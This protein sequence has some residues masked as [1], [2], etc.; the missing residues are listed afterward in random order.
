MTSTNTKMTRNGTLF[1]RLIDLKLQYLTL[2]TIVS[3]A[4]TVTPHTHH[5]KVTGSMPFSSIVHTSPATSAAADG[6]GRPVNQ[7]LSATSSI[8]LKRARRSAAPDT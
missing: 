8:V 1:L 6:L 3:P 4:N 5:F 7:R 2:L